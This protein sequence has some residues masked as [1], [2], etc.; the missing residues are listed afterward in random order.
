MPNN[1]LKIGMEPQMSMDNR[2]ILIG[3][4][5]GIRKVKVLYKKEKEF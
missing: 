2:N 4:E 3:I 5:K 1:S